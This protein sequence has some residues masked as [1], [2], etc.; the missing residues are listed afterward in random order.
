MLLQL[1]GS[2]TKKTQVFATGDSWMLYYTYDCSDFGYKGNFMV[3][4]YTD[5]TMADMP[6]NE[7][8]K[9]GDSSTPVYDA[10]KHY[11]EIDSE[12]NWTVKV[13]G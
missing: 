7:L 9:N 6:V 10:G 1:S 12:C 2:G 11:L 3:T 4:E 8:G 13:T 5:G